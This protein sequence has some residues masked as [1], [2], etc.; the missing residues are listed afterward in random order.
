[1]KSPTKSA[2]VRAREERILVLQGG[3]TLGTHQTGGYEVLA[4]MGQTPNCV[5]DI[6]IGKINAAMMF[7]S[8]PSNASTGQS[9]VVRPGIRGARRKR[10]FE[11]DGDIPVKEAARRNVAMGTA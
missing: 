2:T 8:S 9:L 10:R 7:A 1:V 3:G 6:S 11:Q 4:R 5:A